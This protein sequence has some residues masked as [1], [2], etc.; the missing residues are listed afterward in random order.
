[1]FEIS[2]TPHR[3]EPLKKLESELAVFWVGYWIEFSV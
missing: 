3:M 1:M 2:K